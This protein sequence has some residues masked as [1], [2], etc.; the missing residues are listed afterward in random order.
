MGLH[1]R[2]KAE[3]LRQE[4]ARLEKLLRE[5]NDF[6]RR[7]N[8]AQPA[9]KPLLSETPAA[10]PPQP[11]ALFVTEEVP[12]ASPAPAPELVAQQQ[13]A[14]VGLR[15][16]AVDADNGAPD[17]LA[18]ATPARKVLALWRAQV[19]TTTTAHTLEKFFGEL[20]F[21]VAGVIVAL[22]ALGWFFKA[23]IDRNWIELGLRLGFGYAV[24]VAAFVAGAKFRARGWAMFGQG[25]MGGGLGAFFIT[26]YSASVRYELIDRPTTFGAMVLLTAAAAL[27][28]IRRDLPLLAYLGFLGGFLAPV[29]LSTGEDRVLELSAWLGL[30]DLGILAVAMKRPWRGLDLL[31]VCFSVFYVVAWANEHFTAARVG[32]GSI[33]LGYLVVLALGVALLP[34]I[35]RRETPPGTALLASFFA[36]LLAVVGGT[37]ILYPEHRHALGVGLAGLAVLYF[38]GAHFFAVRCGARGAAKALQTLGVVAVAIAVPFA[39]EGRGVAPVWSAVGLGLIAIGS[40]SAL[41]PLAIGGAGMLFLAAAESLA[42]G[43]WGH[44]EGMSSVLNAAFACA[45]CPGAAFMVASVILHKAGKAPPVWIGTFFVAGCWL[46]AGA[47]AAEAW[48]SVSENG[49]E[50]LFT[51]EAPAGACA[52]SCFIL[53][54]VA[55]LRRWPEFLCTRLLVPIFLAFVCAVLAVIEGP[56]TEF[57]PIMRPAFLFSAGAVAAG[58]A[59]GALTPGVGGRSLQV[60]ALAFL[61]VL[62]TAEIFAWGRLRALDGFERQEAVFRAQVVASVAWALYAAALLGFGFLLRKPEF[63]WSAIIIFGVT[64]VKVLLYDTAHLEL[65]YRILTFGMLGALLVA[66]S[67][68]YQRRRAA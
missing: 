35:L 63:R 24:G 61:L 42:G 50:W 32:D 17:T 13:S 18:G 23:T 25:A 10:A 65:T 48:Q 40:R 37:L 11:P 45:V 29:V 34:S 44:D 12:T 26:T 52:A 47:V 36:A 4:V 5:L 31:A 39:F 30:L 59:A 15:D 56:G 66:A 16:L 60:A 33:A 57:T 62:G 46:L 38:A 7:E 20:V 8:I 43:R 19:S 58:L 64:L 22:L 55:L 28:A 54:V 2:A 1:A 49:R 51:S 6:V 9:T 41:G 67:F 3:T 68:L 27:V 21:L 14:R 53:V